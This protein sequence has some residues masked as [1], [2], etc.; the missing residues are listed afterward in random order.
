MK[1]STCN[2]VGGLFVWPEELGAY[3]YEGEKTMT[4]KEASSS[5]AGTLT[6][7]KD[8]IAY[9]RAQG[10]KIVDYKFVDL[11]GT[12]QHFSSP[13]AELDE[14]VFSDG[15]GFDGSSI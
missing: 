1:P 5:K 13:I 3:S 6:S 9:A 14:S 7:A 10:L 11:P 8:V 12:W 2:Q 15:V 4:T